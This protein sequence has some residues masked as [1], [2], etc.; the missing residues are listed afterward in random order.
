M[1]FI[2]NNKIELADTPQLDGF[3]RLRVSSPLTLSDNKFIY[4]KEPLRWDEKLVSGA[5][6]TW[7][8]AS[9]IDLQVSGVV[10]S[11]VVRQTKA[12]ISYQPGKSLFSLYTGILNT[13][14]GQTGLLSK[15]G[16]FDDKIDK[17]IGPLNGNGIFFQLS[18]TQLSVVLRNTIISSSTQVDLVIPQS[19]WN[20]D[21]FSGT[22]GTANPSG[23]SIDPSKAQLFWTT[24]EWLGV[25]RVQTG[26]AIEGNY[27]VCHNFNSV[28]TLTSTYMN[29]A[30]LPVR[31]EFH[32]VEGVST[33]SK[34]VQICSTVI[35]EGGFDKT[36]KIFSIDRGTNSKTSVANSV[37]QS[38][39]SIRLSP[40]GIRKTIKII[41][42]NVLCTTTSP[43]RWYLLYNP[44]LTGASWTGTTPTNSYIQSDITA[45]T[46]TGGT[47]INSGYFS[48]DVNM[49]DSS[50]ENTIDLVSNISGGTDIIS[51]V[52]DDLG[53]GAETY[54][55]SLRYLEIE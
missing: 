53:A 54:F 24:I 5:T 44:I 1:S 2:I 42:I 36:G 19:Q 13:D 55:G 6:A 30:S 51:L 17:V 18:G 35:S 22:G 31:Y 23:F 32:N 16:F 52:V 27:Y 33:T 4:D 15:I 39:I 20:V 38:L 34:M 8:S 48:D 45:T 3:G 50:F 12:Y 29:L 11:R 10:N 14:G 21:N 26:F 43:I 37:N 9:T 7:N 41:G 49:T 28:N 25:G 47:I 40:S 46:S